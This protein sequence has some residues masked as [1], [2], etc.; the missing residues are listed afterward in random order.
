MTFHHLE[1][2]S[3]SIRIHLLGV[4]IAALIVQHRLFTAS[5]SHG[6]HLPFSCLRSAVSFRNEM[7]FLRYFRI[8]GLFARFRIKKNGYSLHSVWRWL[9]AYPLLAGPWRLIVSEWEHLFSFLVC[10]IIFLG[11]RGSSPPDE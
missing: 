6:G 1:K 8:F 3:S 10:S 9:D 7:R 4:V 11:P 5:V 2:F